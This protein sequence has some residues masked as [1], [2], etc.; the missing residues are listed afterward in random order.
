[1][2]LRS[3]GFAIGF[4]ALATSVVAQPLAL[5]P[6][7]TGLSPLQ[8]QVTTVQSVRVPIGDAITG[9][10][11]RVMLKFKLQGCLDKLMPLISHAEVQ[12]DR[13]TFY[14]TAL[15]AHTENSRVANCRA[16]PQAAAQV[17]VPGIFQRH[18]IRVVFLGQPSDLNR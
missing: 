1:M 9:S 16:M 11:T 5:P 14:V 10:Q 6:R 8:G 18:Q 17:S 12:A 3:L 15:N 13:V 4:G 7:T 2:L